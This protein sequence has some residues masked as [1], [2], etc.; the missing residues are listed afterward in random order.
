MKSYS[1][2]TLE[3]SQILTD[4]YFTTGPAILSRT[5]LPHRT[6]A[7][8]ASRANHMG[9]SFDPSLIGHH[10]RNKEDLSH[11]IGVKT[12]FAAYMLGFLWADSTVHKRTFEI[13]LKIVQSDFSDI[14]DLWL[15]T[16]KTWRYSQRDDGDPK[17]Q[18]QAIVEI[19]HQPLHAFLVQSGY[20]FKSGDSAASIIDVISPH[21]KHYWWRGYFDGDGGFT[22]SDHTRRVTLTSC[23]E[24]DWSFFKTLADELGL[25][26]RLSQFRDDNRA[27]SSINIENE[28]NLR[29]FMDYIYRGETFGLS[30]KRQAYLDYLEYKRTVRPNKTSRHRGVCYDARRDKWV[31]QIYRGK[32]YRARFD[33]EE[34]AARAYD[35][36]ARELFGN[37]AVFN[38]SST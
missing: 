13:E 11:I 27:A 28:A 14:R 6:P 9:L 5:L 7:Q 15:S 26:Y 4:N 25:H 32:H 38:F 31:M 20:L 30:R 16:A 1:Y 21:L 29:R 19:N 3:E 36:K 22:C 17:H 18:I 12:P 10:L 35:T 33:T 34:E 37:K 23:Y 24:Q 2:F 8:I